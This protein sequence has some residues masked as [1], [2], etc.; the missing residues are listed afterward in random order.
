MGMSEQTKSRFYRAYATTHA[1]VRASADDD[2]AFRRDVYPHLPADRAIR[3]LDVGC[4]QGGL[5]RALRDCGYAAA[6]GIDVSPEQVELAHAAG[7]AS[8]TLG[9]FRSDLPPASFDVVTAT[10]FLEH[11]SKDEVVEAFDRVLDL[12]VPGGRFIAR[13]PNMVSPFAGNYHFGDFTHETAFTARSLRQIG[14]ATGF[15]Q[16]DVHP[17]DPIRHGLIS[18]VRGLVWRVF[19]LAMKLSLASETGVLRGHLV[20]QNVVAVFSKP[21]VPTER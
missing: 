21:L 7:I 5:V 13:V 3:T 4:G 11:L 8:V 15:D 1:G 14:S 18:N 10:D 16:A 19:S 12:L 20:T 9:D 17:C 2:L 6:E